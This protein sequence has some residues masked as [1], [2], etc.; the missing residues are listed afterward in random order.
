MILNHR[1]YAFQKRKSY[2]LSGNTVFLYGKEKEKYN[3]A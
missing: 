3:P 2:E 1:T